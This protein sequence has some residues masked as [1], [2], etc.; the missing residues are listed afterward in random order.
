M[1]ALPHRLGS[2]LESWFRPVSYGDARLRVG[3]AAV[4]AAVLASALCLARDVPG[5]LFQS[6]GGG[7]FTNASLLAL[8]LAGAAVLSFPFE[9]VGGYVVPGHFGR[10]RAD[11]VGE[12]LLGWLRGV[13]VLGLVMC[14]GGA[15][16]LWAGRFGGLVGAL[17]MLGVVLIGLVSF[18]LRLGRLVSG[19][20]P[21]SGHHA[22]VD[23]ALRELGV[24]TP[25]IQV[26]D[27][28]DEAFTGGI[29][30]PPT[31]EVL[32]VPIAWI[33][34]FEPEA[35]ALLLARRTLIV[36]RGLRALGLVIALGLTL[37]GFGAATALPG[38]GVSTVAELVST[39]LWFTLASFIGL[40]A[41]PSASRAATRAADSLL[42]EDRADSRETF[43]ETLRA[44]DALQTDEPERAPEIE[45]FFHPVPGLT[46]RI[47]ALDS[48]RTEIAPWHLVRTALFLSIAALNPL[49]RLAHGNVGR[50]ELWVFAPT[51]G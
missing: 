31:A 38:A 15:M 8:W 46:S 2:R 41:L 29:S 16:V 28:D 44:L 48:P 36:D 23:D 37:L 35:V 22:A 32:V 21:R 13:L 33:G 47:A 39:S 10:K 19:L 12:W 18:Q 27:S 24:V 40:L 6:R 1:P 42:L 51:D 49:H 26:V 25:R 20:R 4:G 45:R 43:V 50:P 30:G 17:G 14:F 34:R 11:G 5:A 9:F 3:I 7:V